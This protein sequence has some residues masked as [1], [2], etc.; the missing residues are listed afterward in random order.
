VTLAAGSRLGPYEIVSP[1]GA[2][3]MGEVYRAR[4]PRLG[5][6]VAVKV[7]P[8][9]FSNDPDRLRRFEHEARAAGVLNHPNITAVYDIGSAD[10][11]PYIVSEL[12]DGETLRSRLATGALSPRKALD[13]AIQLAHGLAAAHEKGIVHRDLKPENVFVTR[14]ERVKVLDFGLAKLTRDEESPGNR[15]DIATAAVG[16]EPGVVMGSLGYMAP[17]Q[18]RG[19]PADARSDI[20][21]F[22][23]ILY[24][25]LAG[26]R[27]FR[28]DS[29][30]DTMSAI[31]KEEPAELSSVVGL[32]PSLVSVVEHCLEKNPDARF[33]SAH[34][35]AFALRQVVPTTSTSAVGPVEPAAPPATSR[36]R[37]LVVAAAGVAVLLFVAGT[38]LLRPFVRSSGVRDKSVAVLPFVN[39]SSDRENEYLSEGITEDLITA[40]S[41]VSGL[42]VAARTSSF[43]FKGKNED[44]RTIGAKLGVG[45]VLEGSVSRAGDRMRIAAQLINT[46]DGYHL[47]SETYD[48]ELQDIF[49]VRS[50]LAQ[51]VA[52]ALQVTLLSDERK[53]LDQKPTE[54]VEAYQLYLKARHAISAFTP[55]GYEKGNRYLQQALERD[56]NYAMAHLGMAYYYVGIVDYLPGSEAMPRARAAAEKALELDPSLAEAH[57]DLGWVIWLGDRDHAMARREFETAVS[58]QP[59]LAYAHEMYGWYLVAVG[60]TEKGLSESRRGVELDPLSPETNTVLGF[61]LY[62][63]RRYDDAIRQLRTAIAVN[64]DYNWAHEFL[65]RALARKHDWSSAFA[66]LAT[67]SRLTGGALAE[68][69]AAVAR[70]HADKGEKDKAREVLDRFGKAD[71][72]VPSYHSAVICAGLGDLDRAFQLLAKADAERSFWTG[73]LAVDPDVDVLKSDP[74]FADLLKMAGLPARRRG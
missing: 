54:D 36:K 61:N 60:E 72:F 37:I 40:L 51:T 11:A 42:R 68:I 41:K 22:G 24:E 55:D 3:G 67:A 15:S 26:C 12:L 64:P 27:A 21:A 33:R 62:F 18:V 30:A 69:D 17:E 44:V 70:A 34:D 65:G 23:A 63:A 39:M 7:L 53:K 50:Q 35:L 47:W 32:P 45:A 71:T 25:M 5:R 14:D 4:D 46:S 57:A 49:A 48:R 31:L 6:D 16:T 59:R 73:W 20:F 2:G 10:G 74:R 43:A 1:L 13:Y 52:Q 58:M 19:K 28:G 29:A 56:P 9:S 8:A 38:V 66:E